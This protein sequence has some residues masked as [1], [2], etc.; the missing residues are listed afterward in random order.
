MAEP[1]LLD[2]IKDPLHRDEYAQQAKALD[3]VNAHLALATHMHQLQ[4]E[5][6]SKADTADF[7]TKHATLN[8]TSPTYENDVSTLFAQ[9]PRTTG[10]AVTD[11]LGSA[12]AAR[13]TY[14]NAVAPGGADEFSA[15]SPEQHAYITN[16][17]QT[18]DPMAARAHALN[19]AKGEEMTKALIAKG[20]VDP[21][22]DFP[23]W[24][25]TEQT[26]PKVY[27]PDGSINYH[28]IGMLGATRAGNQEGLAAQKEQK[29]ADEQT[30]RDSLGI[31]N[32]WNSYTDDYQKQ[33]AESAEGV[34]AQH[35]KDVVYN[36]AKYGSIKAPD[37]VAVGATGATGP[38]GIPAKTGAAPAHDAS[39]FVP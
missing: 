36:Y 24:D 18:N 3:A 15:G 37:S 2:L 6:A 23:T 29:K 1:S 26:R 39:A 4:E 34:I 7:L 8:P 9:H 22:K 5:L 31:L 20:L 21:T 38:I 11:A 14:M 17:R 27:N 32:K 12:R 30:Y 10:Q 25:G 13:S 16:I 33:Q 19:V 35:A 28:E